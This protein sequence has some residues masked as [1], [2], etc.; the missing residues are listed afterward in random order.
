MAQNT[1]EKSLHVHTFRY[2]K[3]REDYPVE[4]V[5]RYLDQSIGAIYTGPD[6]FRYQSLTIGPK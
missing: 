6:D 1:Q 3:T 5:A 2:G 4:D